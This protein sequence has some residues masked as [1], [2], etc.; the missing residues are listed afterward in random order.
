MPRGGEGDPLSQYVNHSASGGGAQKWPEGAA[1]GTGSDAVRLQEGIAHAAHA[2]AAEPYAP[3]RTV[4]WHPV[5]SQH[6][7]TN[8][9][10][11]TNS[12]LHTVPPATVQTPL[13]RHVMSLPR[14]AKTCQDI[15]G[16][17]QGQIHFS[18][19]QPAHQDK[20]LPSTQFP[21]LV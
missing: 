14:R 11:S 13:P 6:T 1:Y 20:N 9:T 21:P 2:A 12:S 3:R 15:P 4:S 10:H 17:C 7:T 8:S 5:S 18:L 16:T 19:P